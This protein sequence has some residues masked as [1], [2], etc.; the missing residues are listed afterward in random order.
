MIVFHCHL[1]PLQIMPIK[2]N[3]GYWHK[4]EW[5]WKAEERATNENTPIL[6]TLITI[7][8]VIINRSSLE[9]RRYYLWIL[10]IFY[11]T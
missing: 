9:N 3:W 7:W 4:I 8:K 5:L 10:R 11:V 2:P 1:V 6:T